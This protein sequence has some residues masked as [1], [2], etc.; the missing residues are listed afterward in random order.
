MSSERKI[1]RSEKKML[2]RT[3]PFADSRKP[4][5]SLS[6]ICFVFCL[7]GWLGFLFLGW[8]FFVVFFL[9]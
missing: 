8:F 7:F 3:S 9:R 1:N 6:R 2:F 4:N 5:V